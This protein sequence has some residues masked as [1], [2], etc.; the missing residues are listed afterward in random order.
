MG[1]A[2]TAAAKQHKLAKAAVYLPDSS[3]PLTV[4]TSP[5]PEHEH[6]T[7]TEVLRP[8]SHMLSVCIM[9]DDAMMQLPAVACKEGGLDFPLTE[10]VM[11]QSKGPL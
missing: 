2:V 9:H 4:R 6:L 10:S 3:T 8:C 5:A 1:A 11:Q 7:S